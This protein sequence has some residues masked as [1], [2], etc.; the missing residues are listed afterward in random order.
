MITAN[1]PV[2]MSMSAKWQRGIRILTRSASSWKKQIS[3][4]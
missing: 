1:A 4:T 2:S 3:R